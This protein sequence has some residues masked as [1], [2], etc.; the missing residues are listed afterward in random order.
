M[1]TKKIGLLLKSILLLCLIASLFLGVSGCTATRHTLQKAAIPM[2]DTSVDDLVDNL[3]RT[4]NGAFVKDGLPGA[5][6]V[7]T[8]LTELAPT[9]YRLLAT[10]SFL[11]AA[12]GLF[13]EDEN[14]D[15][16]ISLYKVG[17][18]YGMR[19]MKVNN[20]KFRKALEEG[21]LVPDAAKYLTKDDLKALTWYGINLAK[22]VTLQLDTPE[23]I[24]DIQD[25]VATAKRSAELDPKYAWGA[26]W[27]LLGIFYAVVPAFGGMGTGPEASKEAFANGNRAEQGEFG[28]MD[29]MVARYLCPLLKDRDWYDQLNNRVLEMDPCKLGG[30]LCVIN[31]LAKQKA[32]SNVENKIKWMGY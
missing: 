29:V 8:G 23:E 20:S 26:N 16:A 13:V 25:A 19:A 12:L 6:L 17:T 18:E 31:E 21:V 5:L 4:K 7:V 22:R 15:Y 2:I 24:T 30:G 10:T 28:L 1:I 14:K 27:A 32:R 3:L 11:Y 9:N